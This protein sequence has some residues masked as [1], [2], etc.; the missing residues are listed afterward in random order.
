MTGVHEPCTLV[1]RRSTLDI[2][3]RLLERASDLTGIKEKTALVRLG[4]GGCRGGFR[5]FWRDALNRLCLP[6]DRVQSLV[7][8]GVIMRHRSVL[9]K[10]AVC[11]IAIACM[12]GLSLGED[13]SLDSCA[14][15]TSIWSGFGVG[16]MIHHRTS[17][18]M[19][20]RG[21]PDAGGKTS[22]ETRMT[23]VEVTETE[24][25]VK[26]EERED[27]QWIATQEKE[28]RGGEQD[29]AGLEVKADGEE[30]ITIEGKS[31]PCK[32]RIV[33]DV[34]AVIGDPMTRREPGPR[35]GEDGGTVWEHETLGILKVETSTT[36]DGETA[37]TTQVVTRLNVS[38]HVDDTEISCREMTWTTNMVGGKTVMLESAAV[39][40]RTVLTTGEVKQGPITMTHIKELVGFTTKAA[41]PEAHN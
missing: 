28:P 32:R 5:R 39:P 33:S 25:V 17:T 2:E 4:L 3:D 24:F 27:G 8:S 37:T 19:R 7:R 21:R 38:H 29:G 34:S 11:L 9:P 18:E 1:H 22:T 23:L 35:K 41:A 31:Y 26:V 15:R 13:W 6:V 16:T 30:S 20:I 10:L 40:G 14:K 36:A 12:P